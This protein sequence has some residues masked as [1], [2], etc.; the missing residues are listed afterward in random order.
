MQ[1]VHPHR[2][3]VRELCL[4]QSFPQ[5]YDFNGQ[6]PQYI[7]GMSVPPI[8]IASIADEIYNQWLSKL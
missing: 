4:A 6:D 8:M 3:S 1:L 2:L 7:I 5:D